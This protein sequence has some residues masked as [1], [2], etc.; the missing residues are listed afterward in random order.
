MGFDA[1]AGIEREAAIVFAGVHGLA[2]GLVQ[3]PAPHEKA[4]DALTDRSL[5][6][7][8][9]FGG[10]ARFLKVQVPGIFSKKQA[11]EHYHMKM[12]VSIEQPAEAVDEDDGTDACVDVR[13]KGCSAVCFRQAFP[14]TLFDAVQQAVQHGVLQFGV[15]KVIT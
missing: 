11:V 10:E 13:M 8:H 15:V 14:Q 2:F 7:R 12:Q 4:D 3:Q 5:Q 6:V 9:L 1:H